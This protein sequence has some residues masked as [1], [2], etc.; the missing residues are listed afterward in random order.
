MPT[1]SRKGFPA[2][3][4]THPVGANHDS[5]A[6]NGGDR[7]PPLQSVQILRLVGDDAHI[8]PQDIPR[9]ALSTHPRRGESRFAR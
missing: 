7:A 3:H 4:S 1:S 6:K 5:P 9:P 2:L 8:V